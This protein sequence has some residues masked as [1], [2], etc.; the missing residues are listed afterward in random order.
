MTYARCVT[1]SPP[2]AEARWTPARSATP[3]HT[4]WIPIP[5]LPHTTATHFS[6]SFIPVSDLVWQFVTT[7]V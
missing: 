5:G 6:A 3:L 2:Q 1:T 4:P 7:T